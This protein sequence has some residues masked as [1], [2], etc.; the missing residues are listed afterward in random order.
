MYGWRHLKWVHV[1]IGQKRYTIYRDLDG[2][3]TREVTE[4]PEPDHVRQARYDAEL[5]AV[6]RMTEEDRQA[7][8]RARL[9]GEV[10]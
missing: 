8:F 4:R 3:L 6:E 2:K 7:W 5:E 1:D 9:A 10:A